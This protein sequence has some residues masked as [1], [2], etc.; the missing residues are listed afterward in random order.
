MNKEAINRLFAMLPD[1]KRKQELMAKYTNLQAKSQKRGGDGLNDTFEFQPT[2]HIKIEAIDEKGNV[3]GVLADQPNLVVDGAE[4]ILLRSFSGD[5]NRILYKNR[6]PKAVSGTTGLIYIPESKLNG[7]A[8]VNGSQLLHAPNLLWA[9]VNDED[10]NVTYG[11]YPVTLYVKEEVSLEVGKKAFSLSTATAAGRIPLSAE[12]YS[13]YTNMFIGIGEGKNYALDLLD[14][15]LTVSEGATRAADRISTETEGHAVEFKAKISN[16][17]LDVEK[18][19]TGAQIDVF[20]DGVLKE[21]IDTLDSELVEPVVASFEYSELDYEKETTVRIAHSGGDEGVLTPVMAITGLH[22]DAL[23]K[24][25]NGLIKEFKNF[26]KEFTTPAAYNTTPMG[27][28]TIQLPNFPVK[29]GSVKVSYEGF[30]FAEVAQDASL[31][32]TT[33]KVDHF[34]GVV[35]FNRALTGLMVTYAVTGEIY[36]SEMTASMI[37]GTVP[38]QIVTPTPTTATPSGTI[39]GTNKNFTISHADIDPATLVVKLNGSVT[40]NYSYDPATRIITMTTAPISGQTVTAEYTRNVVSTQNRA[41]NSYELKFVPNADSIVLTDQNGK[42][43]TKAADAAGFVNGTYLIDLVNPKLLK[44]AQ[45][46]V[47]GQAVTRVEVR[48]LSDERPGVPTNYTRAIIEK[49]KTINEYPW[50]ELDKGAV[51]FVAEFP[52]L[53]PAHNITIREMGLFDGPRMDDKIAGFRNYPVK[54][55]SLVRV[56][57]ARKEVNT[58]I[59]ITWTITLLNADGQAFQG[60][61]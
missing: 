48:Y 37:G 20:I 18:S 52:E 30:E 8:L 36:D 26:E 43:I 35:E 53:K 41:S 23:N 46:N 55:F 58:G 40:N 5:P 28:F 22:Y 25:M 50:F 21:T 7:A 44:I 10:F 60:G 42:P 34:R 1:G 29:E 51:R 47:D 2:G 11:Y 24:G 49:P 39:N 6:I 15:K 17:Q 13:T 56:G 45:N 16:F 61:R 31:A 12:I 19:N 32:D 33:F 59:R 14:P 54:A 4:E 9:E 38:V 27:P 57:E 3:V